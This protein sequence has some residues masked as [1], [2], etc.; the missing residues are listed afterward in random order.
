MEWLSNDDSCLHHRYIQRRMS[1]QKRRDVR[2]RDVSSYGKL[3]KTPVLGNLLLSYMYVCMHLHRLHIL[4]TSLCWVM[5]YNKILTRIFHTK[6]W[7]ISSLDKF[8]R[9]ECIKMVHKVKLRSM[10]KYDLQMWNNRNEREFKTFHF[11][12]F[13]LFS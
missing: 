2:R 9:G 6:K 8:K 7:I 11:C 4:Y 3:L 13:F 12:D 10:S 5:F 1:L